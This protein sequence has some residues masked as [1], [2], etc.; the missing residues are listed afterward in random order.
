MPGQS[1]IDAPG[2]SAKITIVIP[3]YQTLDL[4][5]AYLLKNKLNQF[6][7]KRISQFLME[8]LK[9]TNRENKSV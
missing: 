1:R 7:Q 8:L 5:Y 9:Q 2:A 4:I 3:H 6:S